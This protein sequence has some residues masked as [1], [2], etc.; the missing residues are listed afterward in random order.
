MNGLI[1][2]PVSPGPAFDELSCDQSWAFPSQ[3][4]GI[5]ASTGE[6]VSIGAI[7]THLKC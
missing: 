4:P 2:P 3:M 1:G 6:A 7:L 5:I